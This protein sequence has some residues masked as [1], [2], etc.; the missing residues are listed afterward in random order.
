MNS[1]PKKLL[2]QV[3][4]VI[5]LKHY[6]YHTE[7]QYLR[8]IK[9]YILFHN[10]QHP[11]YLGRPHIEAY[12]THLAVESKVAA[13]TQNQ[14]LNA[15][16]SSTIPSS[17]IPSMNLSMPYAPKDLNGSPPSLQRKKPRLSSIASQVHSASWH[18]CFTEADYELVNVSA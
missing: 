13:S 9:R 15:L 14:A 2:D 18:N 5:R 1:Q 8:W 17:N 3:R 12:L 7:K 4:D 11:K 6:S 16:L 10:K